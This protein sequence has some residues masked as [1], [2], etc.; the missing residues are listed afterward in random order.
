MVA[1][2]DK[3][4]RSDDLARE[5]SEGRKATRGAAAAV[6]LNGKEAPEDLQ[7]RLD[8]LTSQ[9]EE[10]SNRHES[11]REAN[12]KLETL[13]KLKSNF[14]AVASHEL[15]TPISIIKG[16]NRML[17]DEA[18]GPLSEDQRQLL[19]DC[20][21]GCD[22]MIRMIDS[23]LDLSKIESG[24]L[25]MNLRYGDLGQLVSGMV[26]QMETIALREKVELKNQLAA[27]LPQTL[28]DAEKINQVLMNLLENA[29]KFTPAGG[30]VTVRVT[31]CRDGA[32][33]LR[34]SQTDRCRPHCSPWRR[35]H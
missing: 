25:E 1:S 9:L 26:R 14:L 11:L 24:K 34:S 4:Q 27:G 6:A 29:I 32:R 8:R 12:E 19:T 7:V 21:D 3:Q 10:L 35:A 15:R 20:K 2:T 23:M 28:F 22:R 5:S 31:C 33:G 17:L 13:D 30:R 18:C 16:Y